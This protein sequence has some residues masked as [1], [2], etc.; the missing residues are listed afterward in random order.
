MSSQ[1]KSSTVSETFPTLL[2]AIAVALVIYSLA[3]KPILPAADCPTG[4]SIVVGGG[5]R[6]P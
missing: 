1:Q 3:S 4:G 2:L 5:L 6:E